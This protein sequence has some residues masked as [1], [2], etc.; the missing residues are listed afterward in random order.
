MIRGSKAPTSPQFYP[1]KIDPLGSANSPGRHA[2][3]VSIRDDGKDGPTPQILQVFNLFFRHG[4]KIISQF[5]YFDTEFV[6]TLHCDMRQ[7]NID[8]AGLILELRM[9]KFVTHATTASMKNRIFDGF[10]F[11]LTF[12]GSRAFALDAKIAF[13]LEDNFKTPAEKEMLAEV[14][15]LFSRNVVKEIRAR[16]PPGTQE[17][18]VEENLKDYFRAAGFGRINFFG[19]PKESVRAIIRDPP[20]SESAGGSA[21]GNHFLWGVVLGLLE[22]LQDR[23]LRVVEDLH[24]PASGRL[25]LVLADEA[26]LKSKS[27][28]P[29][30][31]HAKALSEVEKVISSLEKSKDGG[32]QNI[33]ENSEQIEVLAAPAVE[34]VQTFDPTLNQVLKYYERRGW[35]SRKKIPEMGLNANSQAGANDINEK[36]K[37]EPQE[38]PPKPVHRSLEPPPEEEHSEPKVAPSTKKKHISL[39]NIEAKAENRKQKRKLSESEL[40]TAIRQEISED[41]RPL[42]EE[43]PFYSDYTV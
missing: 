10:F 32:S 4:A 7:A 26:S 33:L 30:E 3:R 41:E 40:A 22:S 42:F 28:M 29:S 9:M 18:I 25:F 17:D 36:L 35:A 5:G 2:F 15:R 13:L 14:G 6:L 1:F 31:I 20:V 23:R 37:I 19:D 34:Q 12:L 24:D 43:E 27:E 8:P 21:T 11:P 16:L 39:D 38:A